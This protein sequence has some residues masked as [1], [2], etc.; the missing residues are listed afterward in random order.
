M[1]ESYIRK[2]RSFRSD[3]AQKYIGKYTQKN[4]YTF[5]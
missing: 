2:E 3:Q 5:L 1:S 4:N